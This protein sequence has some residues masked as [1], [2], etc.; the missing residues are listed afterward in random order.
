[1]L[2]KNGWR[3][4]EAIE[5]Q[6]RQDESGIYTVIH[7]TPE[8]KLR[9]DVMDTVDN[10]VVSIVS[11]TVGG[12]YK[13]LADYLAALKIEISTEHALYIGSELQRCN[14]LRENYV[15]D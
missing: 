9:L 15:Q 5:R 14:T 1:M 6:W 4:I 2:T 7:W 10:P 12:V 3:L 11:K 13:A 8:N